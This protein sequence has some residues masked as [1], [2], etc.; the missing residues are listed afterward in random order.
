MKVTSDLDAEDLLQ[1]ARDKSV[2]GR[3]RLAEIVGDLFLGKSNV[4][5]EQERVIMT[6]ILRHLIHDVE[7]NVRK[8]LADRLASFP[9]APAELVRTLA[10]DEIEVAHNILRQTPVLHDLELIEIIQHRTYEHQLSIAMRDSVSEA[11]SDA[12]VETGNV[13]VIKTL[14]ENPRADISDN[15][16]EYLVS[17]SEHRKPLQQPLLERPDMNPEL[18]KKMYWWVSAAL[19]QHI[20]D[21]YDIDVSELD[22]AMEG[23]V[24]QL[25][26]DNPGKAS[27]AEI[28]DP[29]ALPHRQRM[30]EKYA[31]PVE[32]VSASDL[33][34]LLRNGDI[35]RFLAV[36]SRASGLRT[37]LIKRLVYEPG[38]EGLAIICKSSGMSKSDFS[39]LFL[40]SRAARP[41]DQSVDPKEVP[42]AL[43]FFDKLPMETAQ[44]VTARWRLDP[45][46]LFALKQVE[47]PPEE[48]KNAKSA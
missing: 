4:L 11:V 1:L 9:H 31:D 37:Q 33:L 20:M 25:M 16:M 34:Q 39:S 43:A 14:V 6:E 24:H 10:N 36:F 7:M 41:G 13:T 28:I 40:L 5:S 30:T 46:Y 18:A 48:T 32:G 29:S 27:T 2:D 3:T 44:K 15:T 19:R 42:K 12:L 23:S 26:G 17:E 38:G 35:A 22:A 45:D 8:T 47:R 21:Q